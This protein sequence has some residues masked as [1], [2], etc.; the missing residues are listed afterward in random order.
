M[1]LVPHTSTIDNA[2]Y[3]YQRLFALKLIHNQEK[4]GKIF[5]IEIPMQ[6]QEDEAVMGR[7]EGEESD[8]KRDNE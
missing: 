4:S 2:F 5:N 6:L 7:V 8:G 1:S 3:Y